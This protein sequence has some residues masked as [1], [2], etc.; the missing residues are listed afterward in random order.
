[1]NSSLQNRYSLYL[2]LVANVPDLENRDRDVVLVRRTIHL[3]KPRGVEKLEW[4]GNGEGMG[5]ERGGN[6]VGEVSLRATWGQGGRDCTTQKEEFQVSK[7]EL[8]G[9]LPT[10][11]KK[12]N[13]AITLYCQSMYMYIIIV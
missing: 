5:R 1:V 3:G 9:K 13:C 7:R 12:G 8:T 6:G 2:P 10:G 11:V 4:G